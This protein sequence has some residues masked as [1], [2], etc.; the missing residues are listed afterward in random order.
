MARSHPSAAYG[1]HGDRLRRVLTDGDR[2]AMS[3]DKRCVSRVVSVVATAAV[4]VGMTA[5]AG[6]AKPRPRVTKPTLTANVPART[7]ATSVTFT[8]SSPNATKYTCSLDGRKSTC[9]SPK[10]YAGLVEGAHSF[11]VV[12]TATGLRNSPAAT[13]AWTVDRTPPPA[14][15]FNAVPT[16]PVQASPN[17]TF[18]GEVGDTF[19]CDIDGATQPC[20]G[21]S[22]GTAAVATKGTHSLTVVPTD[23]AGNVGPAAL[24]LLLLDNDDPVISVS[25]PPPASTSTSPIDISFVVTGADAPSHAVQ[26]ELRHG[27]TVDAIF[28]D[29]P[30]SAAPNSF[31][32]SAATAVDGATYTLTI[33]ATDAA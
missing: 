33:K 11:S 27:I 2:W 1:H 23:Q 5:S 18:T 20:T 9:T 24:A 19:T 22:T 4:V 26:C 15:T 29:C 14:V 10:N 25:N 8:F 12:G 13:F 17:I 16:A 31:H 30:T 7:N 6:M 21:N 3:I 28:A 32:Y